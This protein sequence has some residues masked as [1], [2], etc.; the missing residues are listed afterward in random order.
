M[1]DRSFLSA[2]RFFRPKGEKYGC[3]EEKTA[4]DWGEIRCGQREWEDFFRKRWQYDKKVRST[5]GVNCTG[6]C[7]WDVYVKNGILVWETQR[8][9]QI[10][11]PEVV[12]VV[13]PT[14]GIPTVR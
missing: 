5:H 13:R 2:L 12:R 1:P 3:K 14:P 11:N 10:T 4:D 7:S 6:S 8:D 9:F